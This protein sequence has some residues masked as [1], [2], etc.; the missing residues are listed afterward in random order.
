MKYHKQKFRHDPANG[1]FGD[2]QRTA[3]ACLLD[4]ELDEVPNFGIHYDDQAA[5]YKAI[6]EYLATE[7]LGEFHFCYN[8]CELDDVLACMA[9]WN[10]NLHYMIS[11]RSERGF[12][13]VVICKGGAMVHDPHED[14]TFINKPCTD[15]YYWVSVIA[16]LSGV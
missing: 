15:G 8:N 1:L 10:K 6:D 13:H 3:I 2:C 9:M 16:K 14:N 5:F 11:G 7:G 4:K 12:N